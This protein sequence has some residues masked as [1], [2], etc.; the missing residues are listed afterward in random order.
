MQNISHDISGVGPLVK[1]LARRGAPACPEVFSTGV[2]ALD[3]HLGGGLRR[4]VVHE[5]FA[6]DTGQSQA[7]DGFALGLVLRSEPKSLVWVLQ[8]R[9]FSE[10]GVPYGPGVED[11]GL[12]TGSLVMV[13]V[14]DAAQL[15]SAGEEAL[16]SGAADAVL[17]SVWGNAPAFTLTA[18][19]RLAL[20]ATRGR[21]TG[22]FVRAAASPAPST[23]ETRW[24]VRAVPSTPLEAQ[25][26]GLPALAVELLRSRSGAPSGEWI[27]EWDREARTF[28]APAAPRDL[29][30]L[31]ADRAT[32][33]VGGRRRAA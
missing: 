15:L 23:A 29:V 32:G 14:R 12:E 10:A 4:E 16:A 18:S 6:A 30:S 24:R 31:P 8:S 9:A 11:W 26:P 19:R 28:A 17:M 1:G 5:F 3:A 13:T 20:A 7:A 27:V 2:A 33:T 21:S 22:F 25:A